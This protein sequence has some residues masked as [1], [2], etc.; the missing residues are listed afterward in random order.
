MENEIRASVNILAECIS[1]VILPSSIRLH[2]HR[3]TAKE[4]CFELFLQI[5]LPGYFHG[6]RGKRILGS[7]D[8]SDFEGTEIYFEDTREANLSTHYYFP[9]AIATNCSVSL[10][11]P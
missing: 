9:V 7:V 4:K 5:S 3:S 1:F 6:Q 8:F 11:L 10:D 2:L